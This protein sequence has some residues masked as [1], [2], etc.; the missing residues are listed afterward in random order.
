VLRGKKPFK[1]KNMWLKVEGFVALLKQWWDSYV[2]QGMLSFVFA[3]KIKALKMNLKTWNEEVFRNIGRN[4]RN[5]LEDLRMFDVHE[6]SRAFDEEE[7]RRKA[8][9]V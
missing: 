8:K 9:V 2:F 5:L 4:K 3:C 6:E 1:F 7:F